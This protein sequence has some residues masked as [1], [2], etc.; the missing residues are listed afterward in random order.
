MCTIQSGNGGM[1]HGIEW[2][3]LMFQELG[4]AGS[5]ANASKLIEVCTHC[6]S[7]WLVTSKLLNEWDHWWLNWGAPGRMW[8]TLHTNG[9]ETSPVCI[10]HPTTWSPN[11]SG[12]GDEWK[13]HWQLGSF[14]AFTQ[15]LMAIFMQ[16][17]MASANQGHYGFTY[18]KAM[19]LLK[20]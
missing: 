4:P 16:A 18:C 15:A 14:F 7:K 13:E 2:Q 3:H 8:A 5:L 1:I 17:S 6:K 9:W 10:S 11:P 12:N 19:C 20:F